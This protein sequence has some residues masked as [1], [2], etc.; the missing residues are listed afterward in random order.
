[1]IMDIDRRQC[2][3]VNIDANWLDLGVPSDCYFYSK[4]GCDV[5]SLILSA[6]GPNRFY[7]ANF[8]RPWYQC[9]KAGQNSTNGT[10][11]G[12]ALKAARA[13]TGGLKVGTLYPRDGMSVYF[14]YSTTHR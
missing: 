1:M 7:L 3:S 11:T 4:G 14:R 13:V 2:R 10:T 12:V 8:G 9:E 5:G 6:H